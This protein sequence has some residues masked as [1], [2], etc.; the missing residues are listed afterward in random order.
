MA[1]LPLAGWQIFYFR[2][3]AWSNPLSSRGTPTAQSVGQASAAAKAQALVPD[4]I[5]L[6]LDL[7]PNDALAGRLTRDWVNPLNG[8][9]KS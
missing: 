5:R 9:G 4:G 1:L 8:G 3:N 6:Q 7:G 2:G